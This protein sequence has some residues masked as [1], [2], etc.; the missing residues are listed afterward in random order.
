MFKYMD[1]AEREQLDREASHIDRMLHRT[2][3][4]KLQAFIEATLKAGDLAV[5]SHW[6]SH[7][8]KSED[9]GTYCLGCAYRKVAELDAQDG[10]MPGGEE[11]GWMVSGGYDV[12]SG[13]RCCDS[14]GQRFAYDLDECHAADE[15]WHYT[16]GRSPGPVDCTHELL[17]VHELASW[18]VYLGPSW[19]REIME[20][21]KVVEQVDMAVCLAALP[22][23]IEKV[24]KKR[25]ADELEERQRSRERDRQ[26]REREEQCAA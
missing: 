5:M 12:E 4:T 10:W 20:V 21:V 1:R 2:C 3:V 15:L 19:I 24:T 26:A 9:E 22:N 25:E 8:E 13:P 6:L 11:D 23:D 18:A 16:K 14:C 17:D 7:D